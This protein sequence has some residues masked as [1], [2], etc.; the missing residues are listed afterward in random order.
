MYYFPLTVL[1][2]IAAFQ[3]QPR[4]SL[5]VFTYIHDCDISSLEVFLTANDVNGRYG[6]DS[7][8]LLSYAILTDQHRVIHYLTEAGADVNQNY[9]GTPPLLLAVQN[10]QQQSVRLL[11]RYGAFLNAVDS[12]GNSAL[13]HAA[14]KGNLEITKTLVR[15]G[16]N[17]NYINPGFNRAYD[18]AVK[19]NFQEVSEYL[20]DQYER[21]LPDMRDGPFVRWNKNKII[22]C[23]LVHDSIRNV[24]KKVR[25]NF[26]SDSIFFSFNGFAGDSGSYR[27]RKEMYIPGG[28]FD[29]IS[30]ILVMGDIHGGYDSL[31]LF[32]KNNG[33]IDQKNYWIW[34]N[35][36]LVFLGDVFDRGNEVTEALWFIYHLE[37]QAQK[38]GGLVHFILGNHEMM[39]LRNESSY[40]ADKYYYLTKKA[41]VSYSSLFNKKTILGSWLR[42]RN[43]IIKINDHLFVH[44][45]ISPALAFSGLS[46]NE[47]N[48]MVR[49]YN[50]H[51]E[52]HPYSLETEDL[53]LGPNGPF[54]FRGY[55]EASRFY[56]R[57]SDPDIDTIF[58]VYDISSMFVGHTN[59]TN[60]MSLF[61]NRVYPLDVPHYTRNYS[62]FGLLLKDKDIYLLNS[63]GNLLRME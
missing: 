20:R 9:M 27:L 52:R 28:E 48:N 7:I 30:R 1:I 57:V 32:L 60:V 56:K 13:I 42:S 58:S 44:A 36:H 51:P 4:D 23:Y 18:I 17:I 54:W 15:Q 50:N 43:T 37:E 3:Q 45:G 59:V 6:F 11:I 63:S 34:G 5:P 33:V 10:N 26:Q 2:S 35:G 61:H 62:I 19:S 53:L 39:I 31:L 49:V 24:T 38:Q 40:I 29:N 55:F 46:I 25:K 8:T 14:S 41:K 16:A 47:I 12:K 22:S 21:N